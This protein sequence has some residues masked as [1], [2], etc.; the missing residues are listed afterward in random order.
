MLNLWEK[1]K[2]GAFTKTLKQTC[3]KYDAT[4]ASEDFQNKHIAKILAKSVET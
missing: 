4:F 3:E 2:P 1:P